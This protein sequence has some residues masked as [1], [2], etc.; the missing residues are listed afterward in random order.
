MRRFEILGGLAI[1]LSAITGCGGGTGSVSFDTW[2][3][4][5]I[6]SEI[7]ASDFED[8]WAVTYEKFLV[9]IGHVTVADAEGTIG[10]RMEGTTVFDHT[11]P[12]VKPVFEATGLEAG[13][14]E[15]VSYEIPVAE[16]SA[17]LADGV[18]EGD[19]Q[20]LVDRQASIH[21]IGSATKGG[22]TKTFEWS[23]TAGTRYEECTADRDGKQTAGALVT[24]GGTDQIQL[25]IHGD[26]LFY[27]DLQ[28]A[29]AALRF[30]PIAAAD[31]D[32]DGAVTLEEL[33]AVKLYDIDVGTYGT[34][35]ADGVD[36]L[37]AFVRALSQTVGH[38]RGEGEC[39]GRPL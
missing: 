14:W 38:F 8:G 13:P 11:L 35:S 32:G 30:D 3:E 15:K 21:V 6:E 25:T 24:N 9:H 23:F 7:P 37:G 16:A 1:L 28:S 29:A 27:D 36:D 17:A 26:H 10:A 2:G 4:E 39:F 22:V 12:G 34:G 19:R 31:T 33:S 5:Y 20:L 18:T